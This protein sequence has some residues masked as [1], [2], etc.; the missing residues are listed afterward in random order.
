MCNVCFQLLLSY[1]YDRI[2]LHHWNHG[3]GYFVSKYNYV[4]GIERSGDHSSFKHPVQEALAI[5]I[6]KSVNLGADPLG[7]GQTVNPNSTVIVLCLGSTVQSCNKMTTETHPYFQFLLVLQ[8]C[9]APC[10][11]LLEIQ[12][13]H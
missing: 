3:S 10:Q 13:S 7:T 4:S 11:T 1:I 8:Q 2:W 12:S 9:M 6:S 5:Y